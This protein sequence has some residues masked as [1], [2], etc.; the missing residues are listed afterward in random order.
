MSPRAFASLLLLAA[1]TVLAMPAAAQG[2]RFSFAALGD[3]PYFA[4]EEAM[5]GGILE[6]FADEGLA[7][8]VHVGDV[9][10]GASSCADDVLLAR[11]ELLDRAAVP[12]VF[13]PGDNEWTDC[14]RPVAGAFDPAER[15]QRLREL[16][17]AGNASL[18]RRRITLERQSDDPRFGEYRENVR[19]TFGEVVFVTLN[20]PGSNNNLGRTAAMDREHA[21]RMDAVFEWLDEAV[22][23]AERATARGIV[24]FFQGDP[25][26]GRVRKEPD[27]YARLR[28]VLRTHAR[29][30]GKPLLVVHGD[31][32][33]FRVDR[34]LA[35]DDG[36]RL[37]GFTRVEVFGSPVVNWVRIDVDPA[38]PELFTIAPGQ[39]PAVAP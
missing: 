18:G 11:R 15:L 4:H 16:F 39:A 36:T 8:A 7:F 33:R 30:L 31:G 23:L 35:D 9:K 21:A 28:A 3:V 32:H 24:I 1:C 22:K 17:F 34:P 26:F 19:W 12:L 10:S 5:L 37:P 20:I 29:W 2:E 13:T 38:S 6:G 14:H 27:G 25:R